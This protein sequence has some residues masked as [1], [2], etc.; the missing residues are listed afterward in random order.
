MTSDCLPHQVREALRPRLGAV[1][2]P[3]DAAACGRAAAL[4][5]ALVDEPVDEP[6]RAAALG[7]ALVAKKREP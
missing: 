1:D 3:V 2:E 5:R 4:G 6:W 7:R